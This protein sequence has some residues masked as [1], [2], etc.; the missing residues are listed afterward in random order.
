MA[1][2]GQQDQDQD[3]AADAG[4][5][6]AGATPDTDWEAEAKKWQALSKKNEDR[7]KANSA[8]AK[9]L[10]DLEA[11]NQ[12]D[13]ERAQ[14]ERDAARAEITAAREGVAAARLEAALTGLVDD[15]A[16]EVADLNIS[17]F[18]GDDGQVDPEKVSALK[19]RYASRVPPSGPRAPAP[20]PA[21]GN[22][23]RQLTLPQMVAELEAKPG[24][25]RAE[26][27]ELGRLKARQLMQVKQQQQG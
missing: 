1:E 11:E 21:Q 17:R 7:A 19:A 3:A 9:K 5:Q 13:L 4:Q 27:V 18:L 2:D 24:K 16:A 8:A 6:G 22:G 15:P 25:S 10:A 14:A 23:T 26:Q 12:S 20:N